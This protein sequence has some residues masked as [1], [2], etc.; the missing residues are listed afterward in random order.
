[1]VK[2][3]VKLSTKEP[4]AA[5]VA[6]G[7][8]EM[9]DGLLRARDLVYAMRMAAQAAELTKEGGAALEGLAITIVDELNEVLEERTRLCQLAG[10]AGGSDA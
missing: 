1:M 10:E 3:V 5:Q 4:I 2:A 8:F 6:D 9:E 7:L